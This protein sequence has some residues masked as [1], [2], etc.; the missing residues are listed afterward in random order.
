M[1]KIGKVIRHYSEPFKLKILAKFIEEKL[2][3]IK[4]SPY[5][6]KNPEKQKTKNKN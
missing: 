4:K 2:K 6:I 1:F 5:F 3:I